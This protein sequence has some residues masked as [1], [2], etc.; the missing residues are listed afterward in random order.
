MPRILIQNCDVLSVPDAATVEIQ[1]ARDILIDGMH[2]EAILP[3]GQ[4]NPGR[5]DETLQAEGLLAMPGLINTH[6]HTPMVL[7][8]GLAEDV[9]LAAWFNEYIWPLENNLIE[10]DVYWGMTLGI[11]EMLRAG[12]TTVNDHYFHMH[13]AAKAVEDAGTRALLGWAVFSSGGTDLLEHSAAFVED[14][15]NAADGRIQTII[16][17]HAPYTCSDDFLR[18]CADLATSLNTGVH[19]HASENHEQTRM[20]LAKSGKTPI[21]VLEATGILDRPTIVAHAC[22]ATPEDIT[23]LAKYGAS[24]AHCPKTYMKLAMDIAPVVDLRAAGVPVGIGTDGA[25]SNNTMNLWEVLRIMALAQ[26]EITRE[27]EALSLSETLYIATRGSAKALG[28][29]NEI[30]TL[31]PGYLADIALID[32]SGLHHQPVHNVAANL[33]YNME[34]ADVRTVLVNGRVVMRDR[35]LLT[36]NEREVT[37]YA[38]AARERLSRRLPEQRIQ[39]YAP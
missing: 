38:A 34:T 36:I 11:A 10:E 6:A 20:S 5:F 39:T 8:R 31:A 18:M 27:A 1:P 2:I 13:Q 9:P 33:V 15:Q 19:I 22:G 25:V 4:A 12:V 17:P 24:V 32:L 29:E 28:M 16:A 30:G 3:S 26:K 37:A 7:F 14:W 21:Q 23:L 35:Q